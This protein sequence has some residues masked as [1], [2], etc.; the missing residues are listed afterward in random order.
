MKKRLLI[1]AALVLAGCASAESI[2][3][4]RQWERQGALD[5]AQRSGV[6]YSP[7]GYRGECL[8]AQEAQRRE[9]AKRRQWVEQEREKD[10]NTAR[11]IAC[12]RSGGKWRQYGGPGYCERGTF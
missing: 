12:L 7:P 6:W 9:E 4:E 2:E 8:S 11:E 10:R 1:V 5:C 3:R